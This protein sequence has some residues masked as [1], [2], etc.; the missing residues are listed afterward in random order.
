MDLSEFDERFNQLLKQFPE[1]R[2][3]LVENAGIKMCQNVINNISAS[4]TD[5][6]GNLKKGVTLKVGSGG[7]YA[8]VKPDYKIAKHHHLIENGHKLIVNGQ[9][10][11]WV[12]GKHM[13]RNALNQLEDE[14]KQDA[15]Q[16]VNRLV[17]DN[18]D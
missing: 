1:A 11:G 9:F 15:E 6:S 18:F 16:M 4:V 13:Y 14:L 17:G 7:G 12:P 10:K 3:E 5:R 8:A 2:R